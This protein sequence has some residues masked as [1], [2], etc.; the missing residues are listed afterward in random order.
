[1]MAIVSLLWWSVFPFGLAFL[2]W[3]FLWDECVLLVNQSDGMG[4][5]DMTHK[6]E[7]YWQSRAYSH[8]H[9]FFFSSWLMVFIL[10]DAENKRRYWLIWRDSCDEKTYRS[11]AL[12]AKFPLT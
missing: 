1:M 3:D 2:F 9:C 10:L 12:L 11:L 7:L 8:P 4:L 5:V 6:G